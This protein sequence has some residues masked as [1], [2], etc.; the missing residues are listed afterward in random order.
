MREY[1]SLQNKSIETDT[2]NPGPTAAA[3]TQLQPPHSRVDASTANGNANSAAGE[4]KFGVLETAAELERIAPA[5]A[6]QAAVL[7]SV[8]AGGFPQGDSAARADSTVRDTSGGSGN[9]LPSKP[10][11]ALPLEASPIHSVESSRATSEEHLPWWHRPLAVARAALS[12]GGAPYGGY[13]GEDPVSK[14]GGGETREAA[15]VQ[16]SIGEVPGAHTNPDCEP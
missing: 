10:P 6:S 13:K 12:F 1:Q 15:T 8:E 11:P 2:P 16:G 14:E 4:S 7:H 5:G 3:T 9:I